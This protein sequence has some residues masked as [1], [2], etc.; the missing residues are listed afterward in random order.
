MDSLTVKET[1]STPKISFI[2]D[3]GYLSII[4]KAISEDAKSFFDTLTEDIEAY[5]LSPAKS[6]RVIIALDYINTP[7]VM[8]VTH[9]LTL[10]KKM[11][12]QKDSHLEIMWHYDAEDT[13]LL[14]D[15]NMIEETV[16]FPFK[17]IAY[18]EG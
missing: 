3:D 13:A 18:R 17:K 11:A 14:E 6:T 7:S 5:C 10:L 16:S 4:G 12:G 8:S 2:P 1:N 15:I 9:I